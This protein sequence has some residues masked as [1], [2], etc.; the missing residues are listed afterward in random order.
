MAAIQESDIVWR[1]SQVSNETTSNGGRMIKTPVGTGIV[2]NVFSPPLSRDQRTAGVT[3]YRKRF[4]HIATS[5]NETLF[6]IYDMMLHN[7]RE[8]DRIAIA[9]G[10]QDDTQ[11][12]LPT[13]WYGV[14]ALDAN[15]LAGGTSIDVVVEEVT[16]NLFQAGD[17]I[18]IFHVEWNSGT[19]TWDTLSY[20]YAEIDTISNVGNTYTIGLLNPLQNGYNVTEVWDGGTPSQLIEFVGVASLLPTVDTK[21]EYTSFTVT[22]AGGTYDDTTYP[23]ELSNLSTVLQNWTLTFTSATAFTISGDTLGVLPGGG[24]TTSD[25]SPNNADYTSPYWTLRSAGFGGAYLAGD[26]ITFTTTPSS[27]P[28]WFRQ[29][30]PASTNSFTD[31]RF[32]IQLDGESE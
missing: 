30:V 27:V 19:T 9:L 29:I 21:A 13:R 18:K 32:S 3:R 20:E 6:N 31:N 25:T 16:D 1:F 24:N 5:L 8:V 2:S 11:A 12:S 10:T 14:G 22:S 23:V 7:T 26:T 15:V 4:A 28:V 17:A